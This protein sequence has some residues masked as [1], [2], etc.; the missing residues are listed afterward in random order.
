MSGSR[1]RV[2]VAHGALARR[3]QHV[4]M[5]GARR[6]K[7][8]PETWRRKAGLPWLNWIEDEGSKRC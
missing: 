4:L 1:R 6:E 5:T 8:L 2:A 3:M 7:L